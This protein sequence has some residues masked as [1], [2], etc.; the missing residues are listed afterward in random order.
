MWKKNGAKKRGTEDSGAPL[1]DAVARGLPGAQWLRDGVLAEEG[2]F[3][4]GLLTV[5]AAL[6]TGGHSAHAAWCCGPLPP[7]AARG[8]AP[9]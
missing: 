5:V 3:T 9:T 1:P 4:E 2:G 8:Q 6:A 7:P